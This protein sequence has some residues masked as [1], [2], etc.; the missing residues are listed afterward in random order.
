MHAQHAKP[1]EDAASL[2]QRVT[3]TAQVQVV[4]LRHLQPPHACQELFLKNC[5]MHT[6]HAT[7]R[8]T[9]SEYLEHQCVR[10]RDSIRFFVRFLLSQQEEILV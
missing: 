10:R 9:F 7:V 8:M 1:L 3:Q 5:M 6:T 4:K 2:H